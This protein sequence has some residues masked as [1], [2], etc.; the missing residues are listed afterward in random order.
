MAAPST[1]N[2]SNATLVKRLL[3]LSWQY[4]RQCIAVLSYQVILLAMGLTGLRL[5]GVAIDVIQHS[6]QPGAKEPQFPLGLVPPAEWSTMHVVLIIGVAILVMAAVRAGLN[7]L[8]ALVIGRLVNLEIVPSLRAQVYDKMQRL[9]FRFFDA[10]ASGSIINRVTSDVQNLRSFVDGVLIQ[11]VIMVLSLGVYLVY[12]LSKNVTLTFACLVFTPLTWTAT[13]IF[14]RI[15]RPEYRRNRELIDEMV[16]GFSEGIQG[17]Q[18]TKGFG[19]EAQELEKFKQRT[20]AVRVQQQRAFWKVSFYSPAVDLLGQANLMILLG[21]G[22][23][24]VIQKALTLGD[25][26]VFATLLQQ[27]SS[28]VN[29]MANIVNTIQQSLVGARRVFEVLDTPIE[30]KSSHDAVRPN[31]VRG[32]VRFEQVDFGYREGD[33]VLEGIDFEVQPGQCVAIVGATGSGKS[34]L[35]SL[36]PRFYDPSAGR[37]LVD[38]VDLKNMDVDLLRRN[39]GLVFQESFLFSNSVA[40]NIAFG[41]PGATREQIEQA[42]KVAAAHQFIMDLPKGY[43]TVLSESGSNLSGGQRQ[44][45]AIARAVLLEPSVLLL[46][47]P[48]AAIDPE[49]EHEILAAMDAAVAGRTTF[50]VAHRLSTLRRADFILVLEDGKIVQRGTHEELMRSGG[51]YLKAA[52]LQIADKESL[53][54]L[55]QYGSP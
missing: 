43:D 54:L 41:N 20:Q 13:T 42:A 8:Y 34:T 9:S 1:E 38:G 11:S 48:T 6:L 44:R 24:L 17:M 37:V 28:Q 32:A 49:T 46:D 55:E 16:L 33:R 31:K 40:A 12:M 39:I 4:R 25:L 21:Y 45:L 29:N 50:V 3:V 22:G 18:V 53:Q 14:S 15:V 27:F 52:E 23:W 10:N 7:Y 19:R 2:Q 26:L 35:L 36:I 5:S 51:H 30:I 47:D